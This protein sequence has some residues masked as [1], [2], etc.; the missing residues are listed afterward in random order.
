VSDGRVVDP[1]PQLLTQ[2][3]VVLY[4]ARGI[5]KHQNGL[6]T[7]FTLLR[8]LHQTRNGRMGDVTSRMGPPSATLRQDNV[9]TQTSISQEQSS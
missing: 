1:A 9:M 5:T 3:C 8:F 7:A 2:C 6:T 4:H